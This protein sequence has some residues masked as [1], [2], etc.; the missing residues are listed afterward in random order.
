MPVDTPVK[1]KLYIKTHGCQMNEYDS[2]RMADV[3]AAEHG[4]ELTQD[5]T[6]A[7]QLRDQANGELVA[8]IESAQGISVEEYR[9]ISQAAQSDPQLMARIS[10][11]FDEREPQ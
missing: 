10:G 6:E 3:L 5:E 2:A 11:I 9:E 1:G 7:A 8:A 4:L